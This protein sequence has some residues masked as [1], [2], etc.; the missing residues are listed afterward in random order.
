MIL[1]YIF[2]N[3]YIINSYSSY[4]TSAIAAKTLMWSGI[5]AM[6]PLF[7]T[8]IQW[9]G[10]L[11]A[12]LSIIISPIP[13][14]FYMYVGQ[15]H[16]RSKKA[17]KTQRGSGDHEKADI[18]HWASSKYSSVPF[19]LAHNCHHVVVTPLTGCSPSEC[20]TA[21]FFRYHVPLQPA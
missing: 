17:S 19:F 2:T 18:G 14:V 21:L 3:S 10:F 20:C 6:V 16:M 13:F 11:L 1:L 8:P 4:A 7:I 9:A 15:I 12:M 5:S